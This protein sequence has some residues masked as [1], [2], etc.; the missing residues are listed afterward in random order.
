MTALTA[1]F[2]G[3]TQLAYVRIT[4][5]PKGKWYCPECHK[6]RRKNTRLFHHLC[7]TLICKYHNYNNY[8]NDLQQ[9]QRAQQMV[10]TLSIML[11]S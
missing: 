10:T 4:R 5:I 9:L 11:I 2:S 7:T 8:S 6:E 1:E 3:F